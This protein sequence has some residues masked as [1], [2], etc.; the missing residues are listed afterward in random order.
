[1]G[2]SKVTTLEDTRRTQ[3]VSSCVFVQKLVSDLV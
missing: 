3:G 1:M 2:Y